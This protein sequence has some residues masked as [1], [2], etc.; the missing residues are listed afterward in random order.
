MLLVPVLLASA[1]TPAPIQTPS[2]A[3]GG[4]SLPAYSN[5]NNIAQL[6][7]AQWADIGNVLQ[8]VVDFHESFLGLIH[9]ETLKSLL[10]LFRAQLYFYAEFTNPDTQHTLGQTSF[11][12]RPPVGPRRATH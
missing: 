1:A 5:Y 11:K 7:P 12:A 6:L 8:K 2:A 3:G 10:Y 4:Q 9:P